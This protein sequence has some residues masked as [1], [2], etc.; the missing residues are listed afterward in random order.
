VINNE[1]PVERMDVIEPSAHIPHSEP[2]QLAEFDQQQQQQQVSEQ[3]NQHFSPQEEPFAATDSTPLSTEAN[4]STLFTVNV[5]EMSTEEFASSNQNNNTR[6]MPA[7]SDDNQQHFS[8]NR[9]A[10]APF[11][12]GLR[13]CHFSLTSLSRDDT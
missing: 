2:Q 11:R 13:T 6:A 12:K 8:P 4:L 9:L 1:T 7:I 10:T 3:P 5:P